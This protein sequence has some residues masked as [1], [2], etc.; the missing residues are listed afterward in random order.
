MKKVHIIGILFI[1]IIL[2]GGPID[3][4]KAQSDNLVIIVNNENPIGDMSVGQVKLYYLRKIKKRWPEL[5]ASIKPVERKGNAGTKST[6]LGNVLKMSDTEAAR[7]FKQRQFAN[8]EA[9]P[10]ILSSDSEII[11]FVKDNPGA[12]GYISKSAYDAVGRKVKVVL[13]L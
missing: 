1:S 11:N 12:I 6:F 3:V 5:N 2:L 7:Y 4:L 9:P 13:T 8:A 10:V